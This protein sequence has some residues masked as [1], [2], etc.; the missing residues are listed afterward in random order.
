MSIRRAVFALP[1]VL[2]AILPSCNYFRSFTNR[3]K[4]AKV[5]NRILYRSDLRKIIPAG[6]SPED[7]T[8]M[9]ERYVNSWALSNLLLMEAEKQL[10][11][12][13]KDI[14][15]NVED[16]KKMLLGYR[17]ENSY[18][19]SHLDTVITGGECLKYY[20]DNKQAFICSEPVVKARVIRI[21]PSSSNY[22]LIRKNYTTTDPEESDDLKSLC[23]S[24]ADGYTVFDDKYVG[25][26]AVAQYA[27]ISVKEIIG[28]M[29]R[30]NSFEI[31]GT[32]LNY[33]VF[34]YEKFDKGEISPFEYNE[35]KIRV[36][37]LS[38][39]KQDLLSNL[40]RDLLDD[41]LNTRKLKLYN[42]ND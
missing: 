42:K 33:L 19:E 10:S 41:A 9:A 3:D 34:I 13:E 29:K 17:Y 15:E 16:F 1:L 21:D 25:L 6:T 20:E 28:Y 36:A 24:Y 4:V 32:A 11:K 40:E 18:L 39:R 8:K 35:G 26:D 37:I 7:S 22:A 5:G 2:L 38:K 23:D 31:E 30:G 12:P 14:T 27:G